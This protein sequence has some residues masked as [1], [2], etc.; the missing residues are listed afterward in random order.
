MSLTSFNFLVFLVALI[1]VY[2]IVPKKKQWLVILVANC[3]FYAFSGIRFFAFIL[4]SS[5]AVY[6]AAI[7]IN[8]VSEKCKI[9]VRAA[10][11]SDEQK[12][13]IKNKAL[14]IKKSICALAL[15]LDFGIWAVLKY[16]EFVIRT[17]W[18][19]GKIFAPCFNCPDISFILPLGISFYTFIAAGYLIDVYRDKYKPERNFLKLFLFISF[20]PHIIQGPFSRYDSLGISLFEEH[21]F[22]YERLCIGIRKILWGF[23]KKLAVANKIGIPVDTFFGDYIGYHGIY[24]WMAAVMFAIQIYADFSGYMDIVSGVSTIMGIDIGLNFRQPYLAKSV[25]EYWQRW[26]ITLG[27]WFRDYMF[28]PISMGK[29]AQKIGKKARKKFG[30]KTGKKVPGYFALIFVWATTGLWHGA[31]W[32][33]VAWGLMNLAVIVFSM[34]L[35]GVYDTIK[36]KLHINSTSIMWRI[37]Q[38]IRTFIIICI[39]KIMSKTNDFHSAIGMYKGLLRID[40]IGLG[41]KP[42]TFFVGLQQ[43][44]IIILIIGIC[45]IIIT[46]II[47][48]FGKMDVYMNR[49]PIIVRNLIYLF[50]IFAIILVAG[51][52]N[53]LVGGFMYA[54]F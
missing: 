5:I 27:K 20:F 50:L 17:V 2:F 3:I 22:S 41:A 14:H 10:Y 32:T 54:N 34:Q 1:L 4:I 44:E 13:I 39:F 7:V 9:D 23:F 30:A 38:V 35:E 12:L 42:M 26:H 6:Y 53:D 16:T 43:R 52:D 36:K 18:R 47:N 45:L 11:L 31:E 40:N 29:F 24:T 15:T 28:Y 46:D 49:C 19:I 8:K 51:G 37:F 25:D 48:E 33:K 21:T